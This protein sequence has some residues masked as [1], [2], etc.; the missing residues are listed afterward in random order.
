MIELNVLPYPLT[1]GGEYDEEGNV[2]TEPTVIEGF[3][4]NTLGEIEGADDYIVTPNS[5]KRKFSGRDDAIYYAFPDE[6][7]FR[8]FVPLEDGEKIED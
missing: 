1:E 2:I 5:P 4:V 8:G 3:H 6:E 7:T